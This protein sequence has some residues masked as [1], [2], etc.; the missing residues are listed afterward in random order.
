MLS[1][2]PQNMPLTEEQATAAFEDMMQ[3]NVPEADMAS[4][5]TALAERGETVPE[6]IG[7]AKT[8]RRHMVPIMAPPGTIDCCGTGGDGLH[9]LNISTAVA[10]VVAACGVPVAKHGNRAATSRSGAADVLEALNVNLALSPAR[11]EAL[12][13]ELNF[14]FL[15][16]PNH[17]PTMKHVASVRKSLG[18]RTIFNILGPLANP[19]GAKRQL[20]GVYDKKWL[21]PIANVLHQLGSEKAWVVHAENG[22]D[23][24]SL[25]GQTFL[26][27]MDQGHITE[28][29]LTPDDFGLPTAPVEDLKGG[30]AQEN[31]AALLRL[32][33]GEK[34]PYR[35]IVLANA[36]AALV[37]AGNV[38]DLR[39][40]VARAAHAIDSTQAACILNRY[41]AFS[42]ERASA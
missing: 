11:L 23:E 41:T 35:D 31:A 22:L 39:T 7:A 28:R 15:M 12:L 1:L 40:G 9:T 24:I 30:D 38:A 10:L 32:L 14:C 6:I 17:H 3:G 20:M 25:S 37:I 29:V 18:R 42:Q 13:R 5:L 36:A 27:Q 21:H 19:A 33:Q 16:A 26:V 2:D 34:G 4:F 8:M